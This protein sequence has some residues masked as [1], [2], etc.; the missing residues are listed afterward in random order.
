MG[1]RIVG[2]VIL[3]QEEGM[4]G[5]TRVLVQQLHS[6]KGWKTPQWERWK[7]FAAPMLGA[8]HWADGC[9][10]HRNTS[11]DAMFQSVVVG[12]QYCVS[13]KS[14]MRH[15]WY[16][17]KM[18]KQQEAAALLTAVLQHNGEDVTVEATGAGLL[19]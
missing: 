18:R 6:T 14:L 16:R 1:G 10:P 12:D 11:T 17:R 3:A 13:H 2:A 19:S 15:S 9:G 5:I 7:G 4:F 8:F